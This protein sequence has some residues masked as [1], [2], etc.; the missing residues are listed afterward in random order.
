MATTT[1][2][3]RTATTT[4]ISRTWSNWAQ[5]NRDYDVTTV[6]DYLDRYPVAA[7][8]VVHIENGSWA[9]ADN[10]DP[11]FKKWLGDPSGMRLEPRPQFLGRAHRREEPSVHR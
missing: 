3:A 2:A 10:G 1:A 11:E 5:T 7:G 6:E 4:P 8:D 9:G